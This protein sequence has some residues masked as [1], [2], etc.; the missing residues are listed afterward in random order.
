MWIAG[1]ELREAHGGRLAPWSA[2]AHTA[3]YFASFSLVIPQMVS[4]W[5]MATTP[6][7]RGLPDLA[8][9]VAMIHRPA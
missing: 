2:A 4:V 1:V 7:G 3:L 6:A 9:G 5:L 8:L